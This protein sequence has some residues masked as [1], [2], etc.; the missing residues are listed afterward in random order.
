MLPVA[1]K[2]TLPFNLKL[3]FALFD[4]AATP[5]YLTGFLIN[6]FRNLDTPNRSIAALDA[7]E[8]FF[9]KGKVRALQCTFE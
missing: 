8:A 1:K 4:I 2:T 3:L 6:L 7:S 9:P 5:L